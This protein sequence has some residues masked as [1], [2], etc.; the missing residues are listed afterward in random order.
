MTATE[1]T[2]A[3]KRERWSFQ[4]KELYDG[5]HHHRPVHRV[6]RLR[7]L[8]PARRHRLRPRA[9]RL[10]AV[11]PR[12]RA[13]P[14]RLHP[15]RRRAAP[16]CT[17]ACPRF[18]AWE[19]EANEHLFG[20]DR[21]PDE[22]AGIYQRHPA[23]PG[24]RRHGPPDG[25]GRRARLGHPDLGHGG[26]L[27]RRRAHLVPRRRRPA[28]GRPSPGVAANQRR[29]AGRRP[30]SRYTY[31]ANTLAID[32]ALERGLLEAGAGRH[33]LPVVGAAGDVAPQGRQDLA[34]RSCSTSACCARRRSTTPSSR[35]CSRPSTASHK[36]DMVK[37]NIKGVFQIWMQRRQLPR[38][39]PQG[40]P[41]LDP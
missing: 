38:D 20:R 34:S 8:L 3:P 7:D 12:G 29:G 1:T 33:E 30:G 26:G 31:S 11:P 23:D 15:R 9:G 36:E 4:W 5:G 14:R 13:R 2:E 24:Q 32:E 27:H 18:R 28:T 6:R 22:M 41:R 17:R 39:Q 37:M 10:Q 21:E 19:P 40:V 16:S 35:S 25:P